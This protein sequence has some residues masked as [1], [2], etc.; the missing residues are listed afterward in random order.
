MW[1]LVCSDRYFMATISNAP[2][3][4]LALLRK[5]QGLSIE[6]IATATKINVRY[7]R[8]IEAGDW[9][10]LPEGVYRRSYVRQYLAAIDSDAEMP[11]LPE[12]EPHL[13]EEAPAAGGWLSRLGAI[14]A[15]GSHP[16]A[17]GSKHAAT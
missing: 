2:Y 13:A 1:M 16:R 11:D 3:A 15:R 6:Q 10:A 14:L 8:A 12:A 7:L 4:N 5:R 17:S 9:S